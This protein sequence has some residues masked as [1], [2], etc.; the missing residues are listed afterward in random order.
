[1]EE[2]PGP[3]RIGAFFQWS[4]EGGVRRSRPTAQRPVRL[5]YPLPSCSSR[6]EAM[7]RQHELRDLPVVDEQHHLVGLASWVDVGVAFLENWSQPPG[8]AQI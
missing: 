5:P 6:A 2:G 1:M 4:R 7:M 3:E 8:P